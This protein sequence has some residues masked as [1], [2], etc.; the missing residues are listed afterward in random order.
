MFDNLKSALAEKMTKDLNES[1]YYDLMVGESLMDLD[2]EE[3]FISEDLD[4]MLENDYNSLI[5]NFDDNSN[6]PTIKNTEADDPKNNVDDVTK[7]DLVID[8][9]ED[10]SDDVKVTASNPPITVTPDTFKDEN[11]ASKEELISELDPTNEETGLI[12]SLEQDI[13]K[14]EKELGPS[15]N[16]EPDSV[17]GNV[18]DDEL[19]NDEDIGTDSSIE[20]S[21]NLDQIEMDLLL[22]E[23]LNYLQ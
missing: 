3:I 12:N 15:S 5:E 11:S 18:S 13:I 8:P 16:T 2:I 4:S 17:S 23:D 21:L 7:Q 1:L 6:V 10:P 19:V 20:E 22:Y 14:L 9:N